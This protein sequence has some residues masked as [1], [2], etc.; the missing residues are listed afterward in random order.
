MHQ[1]V[2]VYATAENGGISRMLDY[3]RFAYRRIRVLRPLRM[4]L[5]VNGE[6]LARLQDEKAWVKL[7]P[8]SRAAWTRALSPHPFAWAESFV[9]TTAR[10]CTAI[11]KV[12]KTFI[13]ALVNAFGVRDPKGEP[14]PDADGNPLPDTSLTDY[15]NVPFLEAIRDY[16]AREVLPHVPDAWIDE[17]YEDKKDQAVD[18]VGYEINFNRFFY[19]YEPP[20]KLEDMT[21][22]THRN[23][24]HLL[25]RKYHISCSVV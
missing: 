4:S 7:T 22:P 25:T 19:K 24:A 16:F 1:I 10:D 8:E 18:L 11:G 5:H 2:D 23:R 6:T 3:R 14:V 20:P 9:E 17:S 12:A 13:K 21:P 15:E